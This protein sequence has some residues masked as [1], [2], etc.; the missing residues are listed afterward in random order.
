[1]SKTERRL[2]CELREIVE[3]EIVRRGLDDES[4]GKVLGLLPVGAEMLRRRR[5]DNLTTCLRAAVGL[6]LDVKLVVS[7]PQSHYEAPFGP[8]QRLSPLA[9]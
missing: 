9:S 4:L 8:R 5:F 2:Y 1:V 7:G 3:A 6:G